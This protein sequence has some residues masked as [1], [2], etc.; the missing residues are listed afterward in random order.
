[1]PLPA[2]QEVQKDELNTYYKY[3][4]RTVC[5][6]IP[7]SQSRC[8]AGW[9]FDTGFV[10]LDVNSFQVHKKYKNFSRDKNN[11][12]YADFASDF[13]DSIGNI[14]FSSLE[15]L[16]QDIFKD[17]NN[18]YMNSHNQMDKIKKVYGLDPATLQG[19]SKDYL[20]DKNGVYLVGY[21]DNGF[22]KVANPEIDLSS[23]EIKNDQLAMDKNNV[24][25]LNLLDNSSG[26]S[27]LGKVDGADPKSFQ[28]IDMGPDDSEFSKD[29][30]FAYFENKKIEGADPVTF[31]PFQFYCH[32]TL[33]MGPFLVQEY[34][35][36]A[37]NVFYMDK[38]VVGADLPS[39]EV[40]G[41]G[42]AKDKNHVYSEDQILEGEDPKTYEYVIA[43]D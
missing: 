35:K 12:Y 27:L 3:K 39:F 42:T 15:I 25:L 23:F 19:L 29:K 7:L 32:C 18:V 9:A 26:K 14:D 33:G 2:S 11:L 17:K 6:N 43:H 30:S 1:M 13:T 36:D 28:I 4:N 24:F 34:S 16:N 37:K 31:S 40:L 22:S 10:P 5:Y 20:K 8:L 41:W 38:K 21:G